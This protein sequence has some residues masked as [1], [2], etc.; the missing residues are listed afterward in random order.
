MGF[1]Y[2]KNSDQERMINKFDKVNKRNAEVIDENHPNFDPT[3]LP[4][5]EQFK[6]FERKKEI[7]KERNAK[8]KAEADKKMNRPRTVIIKNK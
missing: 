8:L 1:Y 4:I 3:M 5:A 6:Y 2:D 7:E